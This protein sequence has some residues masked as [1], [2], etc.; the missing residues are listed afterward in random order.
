MENCCWQIRH[1]VG[2]RSENLGNT[3]V[4]LSG[5]FVPAELAFQPG[6]ELSM[7]ETIFDGLQIAP[8]LDQGH[9]LCSAT[10]ADPLGCIMRFQGE[11]RIKVVIVEPRRLPWRH[12]RD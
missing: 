1:N 10:R 2:F 8:D 7:Q 4:P 12:D 6:T 11:R 5:P 3:H 9:A